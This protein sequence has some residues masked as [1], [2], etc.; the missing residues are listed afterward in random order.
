MTAMHTEQSLGARCRYGWAIAGTILFAGA[1]VLLF[2]ALWVSDR[3]TQAVVWGGIAL[4]FYAFGILCIIGA[5]NRDGPGLSRWRFGP[6][7]L[8]WY[9]L[10]YGLATITWRQPQIGTTAAIIALPS[11]LRALWLVAVGMTA[12]AFGYFVGPGIPARSIAAKGVAKVSH[13]FSFSVR[14]PA[15]P[16][17]LYAIG[18][19]A[20]VAS[21][22]TTGRFD[23]IGNVV[24]AVNSTSGY[25]QILSTL[26]YCA[27][28]GI[29]AAAL[30]V[31]RE[32]VPSAWKTLGILFLVELGV[33]AISG[34]KITFLDAVLAIIIPYS[35]TRGRLPLATLMT[36]AL[37]FIIV[38][39]PFEAAYRGTVGGS[40][41]R[42]TSF[43]V[44]QNVP[45]VLKQT[46]D[47][48][49]ILNTIPTSI[50]YMLKRIQEIDS[51]AIIIQRTPGQVGYANAAQLVEVPLEG[52]VPRAIWRDKPIQDQMYQVSQ[53]YY[54]EPSAVFTAAGITPVGDLYRFGGWIPVIVGM[55][56]LGCVVRLLDDVLDARKNP[57]VIFLM[58]LLYPSVVVAESGWVA[59]FSGIPMT[60][61]VWLFSV[62]VTFRRNVPDVVEKPYPGYGHHRAHRNRQ[63]GSEQSDS[64]TAT[65]GLDRHVTLLLNGRVSVS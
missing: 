28:L 50:D 23:Y 56:F 63:T 45:E 9:A 24:S 31:F 65:S 62:V 41:T 3:P 20:R 37:V 11:V 13:N 16:W 39:T 7:I 40:A 18:T 51:S 48:D 64:G 25:G 60:I 15:A 21:A 53:E 61:G 36:S 46:L 6:W 54:E 57:Q 32:R 1:S 33:A 5:L 43:R 29:A 35:T 38:V 26:S 59:I 17:I 27:P 10:T 47:G 22:A 44:I 12:W 30:Q 34:L 58:L 49:S 55:L 8:I 2:Q 52:F 14:S 4:A 19:A 42:S